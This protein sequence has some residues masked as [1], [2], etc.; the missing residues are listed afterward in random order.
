MS[1]PNGRHH[2]GVALHIAAFEEEEEEEEQSVCVKL[3]P[4]SV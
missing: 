4:V 2:C 3:A 1:W